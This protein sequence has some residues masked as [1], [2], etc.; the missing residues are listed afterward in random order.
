MT[1]GFIGI[2]VMGEPMARNLLRAGT[3]LVIWNRTR[4]ACDRLRSDGAIVAAD[5]DDLFAR[6][7]IVILM[8][9]DETAIDAVLL[10]GT[11]AFARRVAEH[12]LVHMG[13]TSAAYSRALAADVHAAGGDYVEAPVSGSRGPAETAQLVI[14]LAGDSEDLGRVIPVLAPMGRSLVRC[15]S[16]PNALLMK[17][18]VNI[19]LITMVGGLAESVHFA[20][21][22]GLAIERFVD[23][24]DA[25]PMASSVSRTKVRKIAAREFSV[26]AAIDDV[27][28]NTR[29][30]AEAARRARIASPLLDVCHALFREAAALGFGAGDMAAVIAAI[31][32]RSS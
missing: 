29:L 16:V 3:P 30:I 25:G 5:V 14:M 7:S 11:A 17:L 31:E 19:F 15:G 24:L 9:A 6:A 32:S 8:L 18:A 1:V 28:K 10:R 23:I 27:Y 20:Q 2:G 4:A 22:N 12:T 13:T 26:Q 21:R